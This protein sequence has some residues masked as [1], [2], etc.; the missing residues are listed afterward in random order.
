MINK[1]NNKH[2]K[3][4]N[5]IN[6]INYENI[7][8]YFLDTNLYDNENDNSNVL[9]FKLFNYKFMYMGDAGV[10]REKDI[11]NKYNISN[12]DFYK[13]GHHGS[14]TSSSECFINKMKPKYSIISV[15]KNNRYGH[16]K[17]SALDILK[18]SKILRTDQDGSIM[19]KINNNKL[20]VETYIP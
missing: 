2:I 12:I 6:K 5:N 8:I 13:V 4:Y 18:N 3:Y 17:D 11:L 15:G 19:V 10:S 16:P 9:Y 1:L 20:K 14:D 7:N